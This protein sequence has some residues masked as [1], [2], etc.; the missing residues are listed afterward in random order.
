MKNSRAECLRAPL[1]PPHLPGAAVPAPDERR[2]WERAESRAESCAASA[3][4]TLRSGGKF[5][6]SVFILQ[7]HSATGQPKL[8]ADLCH[9]DSQVDT[10]IFL[11]LKCLASTFFSIG[12]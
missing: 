8:F 7:I 6:I 1:P 4:F 12:S 2:V 5:S 10:I 11:K 9:V 3:V